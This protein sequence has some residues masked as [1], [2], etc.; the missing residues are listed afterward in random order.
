MNSYRHGHEKIGTIENIYNGDMFPELAI[1]TFRN[2]ERL[3]PTRAIPA[4]TTPEPFEQSRQSLQPF[5]SRIKDTTTD[6]TAQY[7][8]LYDYIALNSVTGM[9]VLKEGR[10]VYENYFH[11][12]G[13]DTRWMSMSVAKA[14]TSTLVGAAIKDGHIKSIDDPTVKYVPELK[15]SA[16]EGTTV[17]H[18]LGMNSGVKWDETYTN[19]DSDRRAFLKAQ[20]AQRPGAL[21]EVMKD[22]PAAGKPGHIHNY[23]TGETTVAGEI[24]IGATGKRLSDYLHEKIWEPYGMEGEA[25]WWLDSPDGNEIGGSG[26]S[27][28]LRDYARFGQFFMDGGEAG[29]Q[30]V[31]PE[32]WTETA[33]QPVTLENGE[34]VDYGL[35]WWPAWTEKSKKNKAFQAIGIHGQVIHIDPAEKV[36]IAIS[37]ARPKPMGTQPIDDMLFLEDLMESIR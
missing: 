12:N 17:R 21:L 4:S 3:F 20:L 36:V 37:S 33:G 32:G 14:V 1:S 24:V 30:Q 19:S 10:L 29:G 9:V 35:M 5:K 18:I 26:I 16:Y 34:M 13:P 11:G 6:K 25:S 15:G 31:L 8:D 7:Y 22:L 23:S 2:I 28:V 27:A